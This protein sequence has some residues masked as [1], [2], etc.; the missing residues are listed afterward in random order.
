[1]E[2]LIVLACDP[3]LQ[4]AQ[5]AAHIEVEKVLNLLLDV[6]APYTLKYGHMY[7]TQIQHGNRDMPNSLQVVYGNIHAKFLKS[8]ILEHV[9]MTVN[10]SYACVYIIYTSNLATIM[11]CFTR[12]RKKNQ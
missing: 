5:F 8:S 7:R 10:Q 6:K 4:L 9:G 3:K 11:I 12:N 2:F 1:M